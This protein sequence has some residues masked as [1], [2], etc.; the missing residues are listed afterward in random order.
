MRWGK[1]RIKSSGSPPWDSRCEKGTAC[2]PEVPDK[3][4]PYAAPFPGA[5]PQTRPAMQMMHMHPQASLR[6]APALGNTKP[7]RDVSL[8][9]LGN[10]VPSLGSCKLICTMEIILLPERFV[11]LFPNMSSKMVAEWWKAFYRERPAIPKV[12]LPPHH[13]PL[14]CGCSMRTASP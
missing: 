5:G 1:W 7:G 12:S 6:E 2:L 8:H 13:I 11:V 4:M 3:R 10:S 14:P 9:H